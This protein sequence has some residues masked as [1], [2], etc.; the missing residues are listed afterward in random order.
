M[1]WRAGDVQ[2]RDRDKPIAADLAAPRSL[3]AKVPESPHHLVGVAVGAGGH[4]WR[5]RH[6]GVDVRG[7]GGR[8]RRDAVLLFGAPLLGVRDMLARRDASALSPLVLFFSLATS[9]LWTLYAVLIDDG[10]MLV[11]NAMGLAL[12]VAQLGI[13]VK[14]YKP[15][16]L[17][18][19]V[20]MSD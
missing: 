3:T 19:G 15:P 4:R 12:S 1:P 6:A 17:A 10:F 7:N 2:A 14:Y 18:A 5:E 20:N 13:F 9:G 16:Y 11:P 8:L